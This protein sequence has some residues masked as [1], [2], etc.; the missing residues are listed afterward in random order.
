MFPDAE[1]HQYTVNTISDKIYSQ[2]DSYGHRY[3]L[4]DHI[5]NH[6]SYGIA[7][8]NSEAFMVSRNG[9][10]Y[11]KK[12][13]Q[14]MVSGGTMEGWYELMGSTEGDEVITR[15]PNCRVCRN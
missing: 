15:N 14:S 12:N 5:S 8:P 13:Y 2:V 9:N 6:K 11:R 4:M 1:V 7:L 10:R 3:Q